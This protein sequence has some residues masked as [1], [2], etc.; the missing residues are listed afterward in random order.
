MTSGE[1][2]SRQWAE[3]LQRI[4]DALEGILGEMRLWRT[5]Q[6]DQMQSAMMAG[7]AAAMS[8]DEEG[9][10]GGPGIWIPHPD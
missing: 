7:L 9:E 5:Q 4:A 8:E 10:Q 6:S 2:E 3:S 1:D